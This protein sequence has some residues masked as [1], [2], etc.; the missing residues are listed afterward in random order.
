MRR[1]AVESASE[2]TPAPTPAADKTPDVEMTDASYNGDAVLPDASD[3]VAQTN[4]HEAGVGA[5]VNSDADSTAAFGSASAV[6]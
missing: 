2:L 6:K 3:A 1:A 5:G 4:P